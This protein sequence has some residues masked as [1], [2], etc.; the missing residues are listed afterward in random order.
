MRDT[1]AR[2][3]RGSMM[4]LLLA[5]A[6]IFA[7]RFYKTIVPEQVAHDTIT[8]TGAAYEQ[9]RARWE[10]QKISVYEVTSSDPRVTAR[11]RVNRDTGDIFLLD[12]KV[13]G[14][15]WALADT[16]TALTGVSAVVY[17]KYTIDAIYDSIQGALNSV[18]AAE[19][20]RNDSGTT[21][22]HDFDIRFD[23][24]RGYPTH[25]IEYDRT[26]LSSGEITWR[27]TLNSME[28]TDFTSVR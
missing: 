6:C 22:F 15:S 28:V 19:P 9:A 4:I 1:L 10:A 20:A 13:E 23:P 11:L 5:A 2:S 17:G 14:R 16:S 26:T 7:L 18:S 12:L 25:F 21:D 27:T 8:I 3:L 24:S